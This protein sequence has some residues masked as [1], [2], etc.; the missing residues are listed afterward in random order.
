MQKRNSY[1][2][3]TFANQSDAVEALTYHREEAEYLGLDPGRVLCLQNLDGSWV[4]LVPQEQVQ[5]A[6]DEFWS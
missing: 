2:C 5:R 4:V 1:A 6:M 3:F